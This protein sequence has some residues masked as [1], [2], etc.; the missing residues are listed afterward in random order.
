T[1]SAK[2]EGKQH[3]I[4]TEE[5]RHKR[6][7]PGTDLSARPVCLRRTGLGRGGWM[8]VAQRSVA[9][10][11][12][13][14]TEEHLCSL[15]Q[16]VYAPAFSPAVLHR[17]HT[18]NSGIVGWSQRSAV[19]VWRYCRTC[20]VGNSLVSLPAQLKELHEDRTRTGSIQRLA[21][22]AGAGD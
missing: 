12:V 17:R 14:D 22:R 15:L 6:C 5:V 21:Q 19:R 3:V 13:D 7:K 18:V 4:P 10:H 9:G 2:N 20:A 16:L 1:T 11:D 8:P